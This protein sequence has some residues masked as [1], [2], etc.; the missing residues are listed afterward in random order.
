MIWPAF[1]TK[2]DGISDLSQPYPGLRQ[3][4][5]L[6]RTTTIYFQRELY[7]TT[8]MQGITFSWRYHQPKEEL[9]SSKYWNI[10]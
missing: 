2:E 8:K 5:C 3:Q 10:P 4:P 7:T 1:I 6:C 9:L